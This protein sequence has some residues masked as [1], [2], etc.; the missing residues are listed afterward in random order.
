METRTCFSWSG[1][2][3]VYLLC[4]CHGRR[5]GGVNKKFVEKLVVMVILE[6]LFGE[7]RRGEGDGDGV[8]V[9]SVALPASGHRVVVVERVVE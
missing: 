8:C 2:G 3:G 4:F 6:F 1:D 5:G 7:V 9:A